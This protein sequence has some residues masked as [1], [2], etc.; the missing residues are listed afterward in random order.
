VHYLNTDKRLDEW[1][2]EELVRSASEHEA[3][4]AMAPPT[5]PRK[6][7][8]GSES[9]PLASDSEHHAVAVSDTGGEQ[10]SATQLRELTEEEYDIQQHRKLFA[11]RNFDK[12]I[13]GHWQI[14]TWCVQVFVS[15]LAAY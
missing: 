3:E 7:K 9:L 14:R 11:K 1:I 2:S 15:L 5:T 4:N 8:R 12:V 6:R 13:F 10:E